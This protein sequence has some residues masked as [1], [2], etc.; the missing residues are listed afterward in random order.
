MFNWKSWAF[1]LVIATGA[2]WIVMGHNPPVS[3]AAPQQAS[4]SPSDLVPGE[5]Q[6]D[7][8]GNAF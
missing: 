5:M 3:D 1:A 7:E 6:S 8:G 4:F 2:F